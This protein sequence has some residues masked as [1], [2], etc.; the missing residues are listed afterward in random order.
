MDELAELA[1]LAAFSPRMPDDAEIDRAWQILEEKTESV[2]GQLS[3]LQKIKLRLSLRSFV[4][5]VNPKEEF[6]RLQNTL[7]FSQGKK[8]AEGSSVEGLTIE[9]KRQLRSVFKKK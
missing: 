7:N 2:Y 6:V 4:R 3:K 8:A 1:D 5:N 9:F